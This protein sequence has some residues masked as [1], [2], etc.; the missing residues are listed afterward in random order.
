MLLAALFHDIGNIICFKGDE[1]Q[2]INVAKKFLQKEKYSKQK[3]DKV[4]DCISATRMP[5]KPK[6]IFENI[7]CD[8]DLHHLGTESF[9]K[10]NQPLRKEW[11]ENLKIDYSNEAWNILNIQFLQEHKFHTKY[12]EK[13]LEPIKKQ[14]TELFK[15]NQDSFKLIHI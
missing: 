6:N 7:I 1:D 11:S 15:Q 2:S 12:G 9:L 5:Q 13:I 4:I 3:I 14:N 8:A 10:M